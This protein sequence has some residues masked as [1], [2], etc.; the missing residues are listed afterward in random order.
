MGKAG[1]TRA[2]ASAWLL[3]LGCGPACAIDAWSPRRWPGKSSWNWKAHTCRAC[4]I[5]AS[6]VSH[7]HSP[8]TP[9]QSHRERDNTLW[10]PDTWEEASVACVSS[11]RPGHPH[12][13]DLPGRSSRDK[14]GYKFYPFCKP[15][16]GAYLLNTIPPAVCQD[17]ES[18]VPS[19]PLPSSPR[20][21][22]TLF[23]ANEMNGLREE[24]KTLKEEV[25]KLRNL[26]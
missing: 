25:K 7:T 10:F 9:G 13:P 3:S 6:S 16:T 19:L 17:R 23:A 15:Q 12:S 4:S 26:G 21:L 14:L 8:G 11:P 22:S 18:P 1:G 20:S 24:N 2:S 5:S